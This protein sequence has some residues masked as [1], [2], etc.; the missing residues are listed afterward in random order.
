VADNAT[1]LRT[2][3]L[4]DAGIGAIVGAVF[5]AWTSASAR[6]AA[7]VVVPTA[8]PTAITQCPEGY[9]RARDFDPSAVV[10]GTS[11]HWLARCDPRHTNAPISESLEVFWTNRAYLAN[12]D[13]PA[14][15]QS[16]MR[17]VAQESHLLLEPLR[18]A[19][20]VTLRGVPATVIEADGAL[21]LPPM[22][23][24]VWVLPAGGSTVQVMAL[25]TRE[26]LAQVSETARTMMQSM[27]GLAAFSDPPRSERAWT[28]SVACPDGYTD[29]TPPGGGVALA[30]YIGRYC[31][32]PDALGG[33]EI[34]VSELPG[35]AREEQGVRHVFD[36]ATQ[37]TQ[38]IGVSTGAGFGPTEH[39]TI[40]RLEVASAR[41]EIDTPSARI[42]LRGYLVP[43]GDA[44]VLA[45]ATTMFDHADMARET[46]EHWL[47][48][49]APLRGY[50][51][52][53][54]RDFKIR[55][56]IE[57]IVLPAVITSVL[58]A[59]V[60]FLIARGVLKFGD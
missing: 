15:L 26:R 3:L 6:P 48:E 10:D 25:A 33:A 60:A 49:A 30:M 34:L 7:D 18:D 58:G 50:D 12:Y 16:F 39:E 38:S 53:I 9:A 31:L 4:R 59:I 28:V 56:A 21:R 40:N 27:Q 20:A 17:T 54:Y 37:S 45:L 46:L 55:H 44:T 35:A 36:L 24:R 42:H 8:R 32:A 52:A 23:A 1:A 14:A 51:A 2:Q 13:R 29:S 41:V 47:A 22:G 43:A 5:G 57:T 19:S 11:A